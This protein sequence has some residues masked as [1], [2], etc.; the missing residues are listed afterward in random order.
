MSSRQRFVL[1][2]LLAAAGCAGQPIET[3]VEGVPLEKY[4]SEKQLSCSV[5]AL[6]FQALDSPPARAVEIRSKL[7]GSSGP[8]PLYDMEFWFVT[9]RGD[10]RL[11]A[12]SSYFASACRGLPVDCYSDDNVLMKDGSQFELFTMHPR[13]ICVCHRSRGSFLKP[14]D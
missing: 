1:V 14:R 10:V 4:C 13:A 2:L 3:N 6:N 11:C 5:N 12:V 7:T 8:D 9:Q